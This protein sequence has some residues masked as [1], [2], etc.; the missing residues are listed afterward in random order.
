MYYL[1]FIAHLSWS[2]SKPK[3]CIFLLKEFTRLYLLH[4]VLFFFF[5]GRRGKSQDWKRPDSYPSM[6]VN[7]IVVILDVGFLILT[8]SSYPRGL[9]GS[10]FMSWVSWLWNKHL[11]MHWKFPRKICFSYLVLGLI[12]GK[13]SPH[14][15]TDIIDSTKKTQRVKLI[16]FILLAFR[17]SGI[18]I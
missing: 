18:W 1:L 8:T 4:A 14:P 17:L 10:Y 3:G 16:P 13:G 11:S 2:N 15:Y 6:V 7:K 5:P 12:S 9:F